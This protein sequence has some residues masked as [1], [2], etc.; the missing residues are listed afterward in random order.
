MTNTNAT[1]RGGKPVIRTVF[2][3]QKSCC[4]R[5]GSGRYCRDTRNFCT[6]FHPSGSWPMRDS[7]LYWQSGVAWATTGE[8][9]T[10]T[11]LQKGSRETAQEVFR[12]IQSKGANCLAFAATPQRR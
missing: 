6:V 3:F 11:Q 7:H 12:E 5:R 4:S 1:C 8:L 9:A 10:C 2:G